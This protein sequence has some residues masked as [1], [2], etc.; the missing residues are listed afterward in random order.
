MLTRHAH[1]KPVGLQA[2]LIE[3]VTNPGDVVVDPAAGSFSVMEACAQ[4][5]RKFLGCDIV[6]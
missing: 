4:T 5:S 1:A 2:R 6:G 3:S